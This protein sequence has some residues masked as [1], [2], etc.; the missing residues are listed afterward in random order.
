VAQGLQTLRHPLALRRGFDEDASGRPLPQHLGEP[1]PTRP[2]PLLHQFPLGGE[3]AEL[4]LALEQI[5]PDIIH[6]GWPPS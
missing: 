2:D 6:G 4:A 3:D 5:E 1:L